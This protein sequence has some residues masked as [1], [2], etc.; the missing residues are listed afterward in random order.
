MN[1]WQIIFFCQSEIPSQSIPQFRITPSPTSSHHGKQCFDHQSSKRSICHHHPWLRLALGSVS[2]PFALTPTHLYER[3]F[4]IML[5]SDLV[6]MGWHFTVPRGQRLF[7]Q[8]SMIVLTTAS[9]AYFCM[10]SDLGSTPIATEFGHIGG[11]AGVGRQ[12][13]VSPL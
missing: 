2:L 10:A 7:H 4:A 3:R 11:P 12:I 8:L 5:V 1:K 9:I 6:V 13:W